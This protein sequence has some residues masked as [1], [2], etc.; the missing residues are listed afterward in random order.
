MLCITRGT[1][2]PSCVRFRRAG[3]KDETDPIGA[4]HAT[5]FGKMWPVRGKRRTW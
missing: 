3:V 5:A 2:A 1:I 4:Y